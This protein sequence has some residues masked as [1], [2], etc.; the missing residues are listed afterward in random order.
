MNGLE[1]AEISPFLGDSGRCSGTFGSLDVG[2]ASLLSPTANLVPPASFASVLPTDDLPSLDLETCGC[3]EIR[4]GLISSFSASL[5]GCVK[6]FESLVS[7][8]TFCSL[9]LVFSAEDP[10]SHI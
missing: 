5:V 8:C 2:T 3:F 6:I 1:S 4:T 10:K 9:V 7:F